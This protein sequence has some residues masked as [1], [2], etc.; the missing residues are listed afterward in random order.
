MAIFSEDQLR[1]IADALGHSE[2]GLTGSEINHLL[3][4]TGIRDVDPSITKRHRLYNAFLVDQNTRKSRQFIIAFIRKS[5][6]PAR[7]MRD[8]H[9]FEPMRQNLNKALG[10]CGLV[11]DEAGKLSGIETVTTIS[12]AQRR[13]QTLRVDLLARGV[14]P[15]VLAFCREE[16]LQQNHFHA[17]LEAVKSIADKL[18]RRTGLDADG[19]ELVDRALTGDIPML[20]I[21]SL[22]SKSERDEQ[23][24]FANLLKGTFG[25][26][27]NPAAH[28]ARINWDM[29]KEDAE[30]LLSL[31]SLI[32]R[33][34]D[35]AVMPP[36]V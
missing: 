3:A 15:D 35:A 28:E 24:G 19:G 6:K 31:V 10:F 29:K 27:R 23:K 20:A 16:L 14:H 11:M 36:R 4:T 17:V 18:R 1:A 2:E 8:P 7:F 34:I 5:M 33:R 9:R 25:M 30:D 22:R 26:F 12:E 13:A 32:H 21:N